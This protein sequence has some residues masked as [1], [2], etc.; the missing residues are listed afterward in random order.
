MRLP[1]SPHPHQHLLLDLLMMV[2]LTG[3]RWY[4]IVG[5]ICISLVI[6]DVEHLYVSISHLYV[7]SGEMIIQVFCQIF[8]W[9]V[10][11]LILNY[12]S[13]V[14]ILNINSLSDKSFANTFVHLVRCLFIVVMV[15]FAV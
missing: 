1:F 9:I 5:L 6:S 13:S 8:N 4:L 10:W 3:V 7:L 2:I 15:S 11:F 12:M 14:P